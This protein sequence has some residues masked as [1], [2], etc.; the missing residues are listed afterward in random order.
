MTKL[1]NN[2]NRYICADD[3]SIACY[4]FQSLSFTLSTNNLIFGKFDIDF[5][6]N[7]T[8]QPETFSIQLYL[9]Y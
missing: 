9:T 4:S 1:L 3:F 8:E 6:E 7:R 2:L 5:S